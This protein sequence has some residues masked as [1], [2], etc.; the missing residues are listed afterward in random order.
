MANHSIENYKV[1]KIFNNNV[2]LVTLGNKEKILYSKGIG[3][4]R[5][6]GDIIPNYI[7]FDKIFSIEDQSNFSRFN[8]LM[9]SIDHEIIGLC[10]EIIYMISKELKEEL[11]E[12]IHISLADHIAFT[13]K[14]LKEKDEIFNPF[15]VETETLYRHEFEIARKAIYILEERMKLSIPDGEVGFI[16]LHIHSARNKGKLSNTVKYAFLSSTIVEF[17][18]TA[19][20]IQVN[21]Q[22]IDYARFI[23]HLRFAIERILNNAPIKNELTTAIKNQYSSSYKLAIQ[24]ANLIEKQIYIKIPEDEIAFTAV[25]IEKLRNAL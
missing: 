5:T 4:G 14:R 23:T 6:P 17:I 11:D 10:E 7:K 19:L 22:S 16:T 25:H 15:L 1:L 20:N 18:E 2:L 13:I 8:E 9:T 12:K 24:V 3:F 21:R